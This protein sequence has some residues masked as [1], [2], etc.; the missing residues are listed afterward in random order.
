MNDN[1]LMAELRRQ[2]A[3]R[4]LTGTLLYH[5]SVL[6]LYW[7]PLEWNCPASAVTARP[8]EWQF[9]GGPGWYYHEAIK[10]LYCGLVEI[11]GAENLPCHF[12]EYISLKE[13]PVDR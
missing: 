2:I 8:F 13:L 3:V 9:L 7:S 11:V 10:Q 1:E 12:G 5:P 6:G 4:K